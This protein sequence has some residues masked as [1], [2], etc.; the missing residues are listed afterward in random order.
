MQ[1]SL[2]LQPAGLGEQSDE[3]S[4][5]ERAED[6]APASGLGRRA[7]G[8]ASR[9]TG[10]VRVGLTSTADWVTFPEVGFAAPAG[11]PRGDVRRQLATRVWG[12]EGG[13][14]APAQGCGR[15]LGAG[16]RQE[17]PAGRKRGRKTTASR[18]EAGKARRAW[19]GRRGPRGGLQY[20]RLVSVRA[21]SAP[22]TAADGAETGNVHGAFRESGWEGA[23]GETE[24]HQDDGGS[25]RRRHTPRDR[26]E[27]GLKAER[28]RQQG[29]GRTRGCS[30]KGGPRQ[31]CRGA[32]GR[33]EVSTG[34]REEA[35]KASGCPWP[36]SR[37]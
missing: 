34:C 6:A 18:A 29:H 12:A 37:L 20:G 14:E 17:Q 11:R 30:G 19:R 26:P 24:C 33:L 13:S 10:S 27:Q 31:S 2:G 9:R 36:L 1:G 23:N 21:A 3:A 35:G 22:G 16:T 7:H 8:G 5:G 28:E 25:A 4:E 32:G 15:G